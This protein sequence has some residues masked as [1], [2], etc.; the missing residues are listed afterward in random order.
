[1]A[2]RIVDAHGDLRAEHVFLTETPQ[3]IDCLE[4]SIEL[5]WLDSAEEMSFL[6]LDCDRLALPGIG[7]RLLTLYRRLADDPIPDAL[8][9]LY[10]SRRAL[11]RAVLSARRA[12]EGGADAAAWRARAR[13]YL[14]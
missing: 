3:I 9:G 13:W 5:R 6:A 14:S 12:A 11:A 1:A 4:F 7:D 2:G 10:R 8:L